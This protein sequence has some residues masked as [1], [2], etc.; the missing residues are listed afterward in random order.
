[1]AGAV[2]YRVSCLFYPHDYR[3]STDRNDVYSD[4]T[5]YHQIAV[6]EDGKVQ[7]MGRQQKSSGS[8]T[9][10]V[11]LASGQ[12]ANNVVTLK[13]GAEPPT[14]IQSAEDKS[15]YALWSKQSAKSITLYAQATTA[16]SSFH[17]LS[18]EVNRTTNYFAYIHLLTWHSLT[19]RPT[20]LTD[21]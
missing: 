4:A 8:I 11:D 7:V 2:D 16:G 12:A 13:N 14:W 3:H 20:L 18:L 19:M 1:V 21:R 17:P 9:A 10:Q 5:C 15:L 6:T